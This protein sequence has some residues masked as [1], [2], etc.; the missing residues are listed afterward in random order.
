MK[1][2]IGSLF[3]LLYLSVAISAQTQP[4]AFVGARIIPIS[5]R[6]DRRRDF[7][8]SKWENNRGR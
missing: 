1:K 7:A 6:T 5:R 4:T 2:F 8:R 3:I